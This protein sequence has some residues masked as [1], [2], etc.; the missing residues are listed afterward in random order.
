MATIEQVLD[1]LPAVARFVGDALRERWP[2]AGFSVQKDQR[3]S[4]M[5]R[6][7]RIYWDARENGPTLD[8]VVQTAKQATHEAPMI[9]GVRDRYEH[10]VWCFQA[11]QQWIP[12]RVCWIRKAEL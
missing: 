8:E 7:Y 9:D 1:G 6:Q 5:T 3:K 10:D 11:F 4:A 12:D 2:E